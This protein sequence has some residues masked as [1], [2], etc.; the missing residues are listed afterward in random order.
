MVFESSCLVG[1]SRQGLRKVVSNFQE[2]GDRNKNPTFFLFAPKDP[3]GELFK[4]NIQKLQRVFILA[5][6][7]EVRSRP[8]RT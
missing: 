2:S 6:I 4:N 8:K 3:F 7:T 1:H 5:K